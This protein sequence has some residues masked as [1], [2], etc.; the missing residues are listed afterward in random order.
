MSGTIRKRGTTYW[1]RIKRKG[2]TFERSLETTS[3][4]VARERLAQWVRDLDG[5]QWG[6]RPEKTIAE[7]IERFAAVHFQVLKP[8][9][10]K[11]YFV[12]IGHLLDHLADVKVHELGSADLARFENARLA[13][14]AQSS[15]VRRDFACLSS[16]F[17]RAEEWEWVVHNPV[18]PYLRSRSRSGLRESDP[19]TRYLSLEEERRILSAATTKV[20]AAIHFAIDTGLRK[21]EQFSLL[22]SDVDLAA[23][24]IV[25]R[26]SVTK[27]GKTRRVPLLERSYDMVRMQ[28][29][30]F[31]GSQHLFAT[32]KG[33]RYSRE[34]PTMYE[35]LQKACRRAGIKEHVAWH[36]L[37]RTCGCRLLQDYGLDYA[38]VCQ[39]LGHS[40]VRVTQKHYAFLEVQHLH[41]AVARG[42]ATQRPPGDIPGDA[43]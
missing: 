24:E 13:S 20:R 27:S 9:S 39:W 26:G 5:R 7:A 38:K 35:A 12:S 4:A 1:A 16:V 2:K 3:K 18:R 40:D 29:R 8:A 15:T 21:E 36:D 34:S 17:A 30:S 11:R 25:I 22:R 32:N 6:K 37:R 19:R 43:G 31:N 33:N 42:K 28:L 41:R 14:G 10:A 23:R